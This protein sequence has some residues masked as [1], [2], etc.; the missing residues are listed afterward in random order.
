MEPATSKNMDKRWGIRSAGTWD[1]I[2]T[3]RS[4]AIQTFR[5]LVDFMKSRKID[6]EKEKKISVHGIEPA[7]SGSMDKEM[8]H[9]QRQALFTSLV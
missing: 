4:K 9:A 6:K 5:K 3:Q 2:C 1:L 7:T 8:G